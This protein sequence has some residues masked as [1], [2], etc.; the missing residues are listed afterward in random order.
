[1]TQFIGD[2]DGNTLIIGTEMPD[3]LRGLD[4]DDTIY[5]LDGADSLGG[6]NGNDELIG[7]SGDDTMSGRAGDDK[8][9]GQ[10]GND[11]LFGGPGS[12]TILGGGGYDTIYGAEGNDVLFGGG[13][14]DTFMGLLNAGHDVIRDFGR[15]DVLDFTQAGYSLSDLVIRETPAGDTVIRYGGSSFKLLDVTPDELRP[16]QFLFSG[17]S[18]DYK[19]NPHTTGEVEVGKSVTGA[20]EFGN[21]SDWIAVELVAGQVYD[22]TAR[23]YGPLGLGD[24]TL[25]LRAADGTELAFNDDSLN[26]SSR[27]SGFVPETSGTYYLDVDAF[28]PDAIGTYKVRAI[29]GQPDDY[30]GDTSTT[31]TIDPTGPAVHGTIGATDDTDW[32]AVELVEGVSYKIRLGGASSDSGT[33]ADPFLGIYDGNG[34][35][36]AVDDDGGRGL[37]AALVFTPETS[38]TYYL[39]AESFEG[40]STGSYTLDIA[41]L[42]A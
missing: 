6:G 36:V 24:P 42:F 28:Q 19:S 34:E 37:N 32:F 35:L 2:G 26:L 33:L 30:A 41:T 20:I 38:G 40:V 10:A 11:L 31:G 15:Y 8:L 21:D 5:G 7:G 3:K 18:D 1:M 27:I 14:G 17:G 39:S 22:F 13:G 25:T 9:L 29:L 12:D 23:G 4:G 16:W